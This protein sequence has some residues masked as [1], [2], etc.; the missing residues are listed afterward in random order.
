MS[1][2]VCVVAL[3]FLVGGAV[4]ACKKGDATQRGPAVSITSSEEL[5]PELAGRVLARVGEAVITLGDYVT[6]LERMDGLERLRYQTAARRQL[7]LREMIDA[8]LLAQEARRR[9]LDQLPET[10][11][12]LDQLMADE[13]RRQ[14]KQRVARQEA[15][16]EQQLRSYYETHKAEFMQPERRR[17]SALVV[18][19]R[20]KA[21][22][23]LAEAKTKPDGWWQLIRAHSIRP[24]PPTVSRDG[25]T[26]RPPLYLEGDLGLAAAPGVEDEVN[27][28]VPRAVRQV[29][30]EL[31]KVGDFAPEPVQ[32][33]DRYYAIRLMSIQAQRQQPY[34]EVVGRIRGRL[35]E[36]AVMAA[37]EK[38]V[39]ELRTRYE[40]RVD[41]ERLNQL[42]LPT[43]T[44]AAPADAAGRAGAGASGPAARP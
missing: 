30:F 28:E 10:V 11:A 34:E 32:V 5:S 18:S 8:E 25:T 22:H 27:P 37:E 31:A 13:V 41:D 42:K 44:P 29:A 4:T 15:P 35:L 24:S 1:V 7:L 39:S 36:A 17:V 40:I 33:G 23:L 38:L 3:L 6:T 16:T 43:A 14:L 26:A 21:V 19:D 9:G 2:R 20:V 12:R